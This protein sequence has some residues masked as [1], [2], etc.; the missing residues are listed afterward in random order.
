MT[1]TIAAPKTEAPHSGPLDGLRSLIVDVGV[2][3]GT[4]YL[5]SKGFGLSTTASLGWGSV[6][7]MARVVWGL[8]KQRR[9]NSFSALILA[10]NVVAL[11][12]GLLVGD[13]RLMLAKDSGVSGLIAITVLATAFFGRPMMT[14]GLKPW[15]TKGN[16][17]KSAAWDR[18]AANSAA[19]RRHERL[20]SVI[21]GV[22]LLTECV[23]RVIG[24][25]TLPIDTMAWLGTAVLLTAMA[26]AIVVSGGLAVDPMEKLVA[27]EQLA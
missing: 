25:Y 6:L 3:V 5:L 26:V 21:W 16:A 1:Q 27:A 20:F 12:L 24:A 10:S 18:L 19:F 9:V 7:P 11:L 23:A 13:P 17:A 14:A 2:P 4:Y 8:A 15:V 22:S